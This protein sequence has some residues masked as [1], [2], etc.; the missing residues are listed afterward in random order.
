[1]VEAALEFGARR[2]ADR[3]MPLLQHVD[4]QVTSS[5]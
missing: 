5:R 1:M 2:A 4:K 3:A